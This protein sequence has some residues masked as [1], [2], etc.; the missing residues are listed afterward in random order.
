MRLA[1][2]ILVIELSGLLGFIHA[3]KSEFWQPLRY[4]ILMVAVPIV[5]LLFGRAV[6]RMQLSRVLQVCSFLTVS[7][8]LSFQFLGFVAYPGLVKDIELMSVDH[9][10]Q[11][12]KLLLLSAVAHFGLLLLAILILKMA[13]KNG[14]KEF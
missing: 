9:L 3:G 4:P 12:G 2:F 10:V 11:V 14:F 7:T 6:M 1:L 8:V 5:G 13:G